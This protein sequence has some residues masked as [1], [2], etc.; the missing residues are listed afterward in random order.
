MSSSPLRLLASPEE[1]LTHMSEIN[2]NARSRHRTRAKMVKYYL[3][4]LAVLLTGAGLH[5]DMTEPASA[6]MECLQGFRTGDTSHASFGISMAGMARMQSIKRMIETV[7]QQGLNGSYAETGVW[8]GGMTIYATAAMQLNGLSARPVYLCDCF[9]GLPLPRQ[10]SFHARQDAVYFYQNKM[11]SVGVQMV[12]QNFQRYGINEK[13]VVPV[14]GYFVDSMPKFRASLMSRGERLAILRLDG[15]MYDSTVDVL[16]N[17]YDL[18]EVGGFVVIDDFSWTPKTGF[19]ARDAIMDFRQLHGIE[20]D[21]SH[22][23]RNIDSTG[24]WF[25]KMREVN[26]RR[27]LYEETLKSE[28]K[29]SGKTNNRQAKLRPKGVVLGGPQFQATL[30]RWRASWTEDERRQADAVTSS[31]LGASASGMPSPSSSAS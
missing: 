1:W 2:Q 10:G 19:G 28:E 27:D 12:L 15:D 4:Q 16:Y 7:A 22:A 14:E 13:Q 21:A 23:V 26:L 9:R 11:L 18:V 24:A 5:C 25:R 31:H 8:R 30:D 20:G 17:L 3:N 29:G 6:L